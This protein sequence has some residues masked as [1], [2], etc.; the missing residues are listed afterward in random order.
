MKI[1]IDRRAN[2]ALTKLSKEEKSHIK[3]VLNLFRDY[4]FSLTE[5]HLKKIGKNLREL[6]SGNM[7]IL[8][9]V[10]EDAAIVVNIFRKKTNKTPKKEIK[11]AQKRIN[12]YL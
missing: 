9:S 3:G 8:F 6:R 5:T 2:R 12:E 10:V 1:F 7:R 11:L 4:E